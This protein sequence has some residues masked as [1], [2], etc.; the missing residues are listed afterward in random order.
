VNDNNLDSVNKVYEGEVVDS[1]EVVDD[2][3][4]SEEKT[5]WVQRHEELA[6][7]TSYRP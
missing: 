6:K 2:S 5:E 4:E 3:A 1:D 7:N